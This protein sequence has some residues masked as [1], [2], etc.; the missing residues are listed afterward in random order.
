MTIHLWP[1]KQHLWHLMTK[2]KTSIVDI[3]FEDANYA[4]F[5][6][7]WASEKLLP[8]KQCKIPSELSGI[9]KLLKILYAQWYISLS[10]FLKIEGEREKIIIQ[11]SGFLMKQKAKKK[12]NPFI[13]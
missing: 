10:H 7:F 5:K 3:N 1:L 2:V 9:M 13:F 6:F 4:L 11:L 12:K 8:E